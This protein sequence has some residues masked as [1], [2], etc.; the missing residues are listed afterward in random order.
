MPQV[1]AYR[2]PIF[3]TAFEQ[4]VADKQKEIA[5]ADKLMRPY[6]IVR[7]ALE[8]ARLKNDHVL[9]LHSAGIYV[10]ITPT[11]EDAWGAFDPFLRLIGQALKVARLHSTGEWSTEKYS[12]QVDWEFKWRLAMEGSPAIRIKIN[13]PMAGTKWIKIKEHK[14]ASVSTT[15]KSTW[16]GKETHSVDEEEDPF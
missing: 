5:L 9:Q 4:Y 14:E 15:Y 16:Y 1:P 13:V 10:S 12:W 2:Y 3:I 11:D 6:E 8:K 7:N